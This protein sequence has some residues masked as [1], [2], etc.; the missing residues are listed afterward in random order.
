[1]PAGEMDVRACRPNPVGDTRQCLAPVEERLE[2]ATGAWRERS[3]ARPPAVGRG[4]DRLT[5]AAAAKPAGVVRAHDPLDRLADEIVQA[6]QRVGRHDTH[7]PGAARNVTR[8]YGVEYW[9]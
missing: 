4:L 1:V 3:R 7:L 8:R 9:E 2:A 6:V 5:A